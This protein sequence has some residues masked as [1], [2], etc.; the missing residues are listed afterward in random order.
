M[1]GWMILGAAAI[2]AFGV[3]A[4]W[5]LNNRFGR[6]SLEATRKRA[7]E[8]ARNARREAEKTKRAAVLEAK[9][10][11]LAM[12][13]EGWVAPVEGLL[14]AGG[15]DLLAALKVIAWSMVQAGWA[16]PHDALIAEKTATVITG[17]DASMP[18]WLPEEH[19]LRL[20]RELFAEL[21]A[22]GKTQ[23]RIVHMLK[24][25]KPLRN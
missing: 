22:T 21:A 6:K 23:E 3:L 13:A 14:Y 19:F 12:L 25:G 2:V 9:Q 15:R 1:S 8:M 16:S 17:G 20:E 11:V 24:T 4:G 7:D 18:Q 10:E 5:F